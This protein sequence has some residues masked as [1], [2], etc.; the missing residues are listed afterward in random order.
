VEY[1]CGDPE[2][3]HAG[4]LYVEYQPHV[5]GGLLELPE[6]ELLGELGEA[7]AWKL[8]GELPVSA[9]AGEL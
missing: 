5:L 1:H 8:L 2:W 9:Q 6:G 4:E 3:A 7:L